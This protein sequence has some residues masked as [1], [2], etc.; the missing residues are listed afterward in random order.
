MELYYRGNGLKQALLETKDIRKV[1]IAVAYFSEYGLKALK[2]I[3]TKNNLSKNRVEIYI[4]PEFNNKNQG[5][6]LNELVQIANVYIVYNTKFHPK[7]YLF[8]CR[9][10]NKLIFGSSNFTQ[11][12]IEKNIEFDSILEL[13]NKSKYKDKVDIFFSYCKDQSKQVNEDIINWYIDIESE[14][15]ELRK[16]QDKIRKKIFKPETKDDPFEEDEYD[17]KDYYFTFSDYETFFSRN[18]CK[19]DNIIRSSRLE[20]KHKILDIHKSIYRKVKALDIDCHWNPNN[21][22]SLIR[23]CQ[24]NKGRV[25]WLGVRYGKNEYEIKELK[26]NLTNKDEELGFQKHA[27]IQYA[28]GSYGFE[29]NLFHSVPHDAVDRGVMHKRLMDKV[30]RK[31]IED[32]LRKLRGHGFYWDIDGEQFSIDNDDIST[33]YDYY[34]SNDC[35][36]KFSS[37][38]KFFEPDDIEIKDKK[39]I[40]DVVNKYVELLIPLYN[41]VSFRLNDYRL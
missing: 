24:Y 25:A 34:I 10:N 14:L 21:I 15:E 4:S 39:S 30:Y 29:V 38:C 33:F 26:T 35:E 9:K 27:C 13:D 32:E 12:G 11:N 1:K 22:T 18:E 31:K 20:V 23:P 7:V 16:I 5:K 8:E 2:E 36:G 19:E 37:L 40:C 6:I 3:I 28:I 17:I 41:L